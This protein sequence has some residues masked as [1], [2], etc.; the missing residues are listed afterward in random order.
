MTDTRRQSSTQEERRLA[1][2]TTTQIAKQKLDA[3]RKAR[4]E[5]T[6]RL[7]E[8]RLGAGFQRI[9]QAKGEPSQPT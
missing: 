5:K 1:L 2:E 4:E 6:R 3:E 9:G 8:A 7:R